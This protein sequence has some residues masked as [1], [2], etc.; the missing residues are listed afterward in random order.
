MSRIIRPMNKLLLTILL[1][2]ALAA[3]CDSDV[4]ATAD[5]GGR[6]DADAAAA[7]DDSGAASDAAIAPPWDPSTP[8][9]GERPAEVMLPDDYDT[10]QRWP[11]IIL[12]HGYGASASIQNAYFGLSRRLDERGFILVLPN[13][14]T[15]QSGKKFWN[16]T[17]ACCN[18]NDIEVDDVQYLTDLLDEAEQ[19]LAVDADRIY[20]MGHSNG[21]FMSHRMA[22]E[23]GSRVAA[24][25]S[26]A[27]SS[28]DD[29]ADCAEDGKVSVLQIHGDADSTVLYEGGVFF[30]NAYPGAQE[31]VERWASR[32]GCDAQP[33]DGPAVDLDSGLVGDES[34]ITKWQN[35]EAS[36]DVQLWTIHGGGHIPSL[37]GDFT[38]R[39]LDFLFAHQR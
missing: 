21:G 17:D 24:I 9:G 39:V 38:D 14:K 35:C 20:F 37:T 5:T 3:G 33:Q 12:L 4:D 26:L 22:C 10:S 2:A 25:A 28:F 18:F 29:A 15:D 11:L 30:G 34:D 16:A 36:T 8:L 23:L 7:D 1:G 6:H 31:V 19:R 32:D 27:G 13:G